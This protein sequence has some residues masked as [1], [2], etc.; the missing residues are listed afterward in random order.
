MID[1]FN[2]NKI[3]LVLIGCLF[4][5]YLV[6][7]ITEDQTLWLLFVFF[8]VIHFL[9]NI[10][11]KYRKNEVLPYGLEKAGEMYGRG[12]AV[13]L[14]SGVCCFMLAILWFSF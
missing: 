2:L 1:K 12:P 10:Q 5:G 3:D 7:V 9:I 14:M 13:F 6:N 8:W 4:I 11:L